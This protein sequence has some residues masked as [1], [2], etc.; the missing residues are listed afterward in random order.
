MNV[1]WP[2][3]PALAKASAVPWLLDGRLVETRDTLQAV[4]EALDADTKIV[5][6]HGPVT[7]LKTVAW[8]LDYHNAV[9]KEITA[10]I[11]KG[12]SLEDTAARLKL[13]DFEGYALFSWV[14]PIFN[15]S[16]AY[17]DLQ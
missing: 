11:A 1:L 17:K 2:S 7:D 10:A 4:Y 12:L 3:N 15:V 8:N 6:G 14:H 16:A 13:T 5:P 9:E